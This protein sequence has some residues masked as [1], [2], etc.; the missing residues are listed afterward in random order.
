MKLT[1]G[2]FILGLVMACSISTTAVAADKIR[3]VSTLRGFW[4][5]TLVQFGKEKGFFTDEGL[6]IDLV[7]AQGGGA[8][9]LQS[10]IS[11]AADIGIGTGTAGALAAV[12]K[13]APVVIVANE[14]TGGTDVFFYAKG[15]SQIKSFKDLEG[16]KLGISHPGSTTQIAA[17]RLASHVNTKV[18]LVVTGGPPATITQVMTGQVD[19]GWSVYPIGLDKVASGELRIIASANDAPGISESN[20]RV[21]VAN[22]EFAQKEIVLLQ[23]FYKAYA[24]VVDWAYST[25]EALEKYAAIHKISLEAARDTV[26]KGYPKEAVTASR[27]GSIDL[28]VTEAVRNKVLSKPLT[29]Q[30]A[31]DVLK[32]LPLVHK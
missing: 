20:A 1:R 6:D 27:M 31:A 3:V 7:F 11:G 26:K 4:D 24:K 16:R 10:V 25:D 19:A 32:L 21:S 23:R 28:V 15:S 5:T 30:E 13:G 12:T 9:V 8:D 17:S 22:K 18:D 29:Q 2:A 14:M